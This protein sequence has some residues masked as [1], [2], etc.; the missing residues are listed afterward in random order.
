M[1]Q[2]KEAVKWVKSTKDEGGDTERTG[3][4]DR[5]RIF[6]QV[7]N[8]L[9]NPN[10]K[11]FVPR[12]QTK[13]FMNSLKL[14]TAVTAN[15]RHGFL[16]FLGM[17]PW[18]D[19]VWAGIELKKPHHDSCPL[20]DF[21]LELPEKIVRVGVDPSVQ[22]DSERVLATFDA[23]AK[24]GPKQKKKDRDAAASPLGVLD[25]MPHTLSLCSSNVLLL[26]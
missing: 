9:T 3:R 5:K 23:P 8:V 17:V 2:Q 20:V 18:G 24:Q 16:L 13:Q 26:G 14:R 22:P 19:G 11:V 4:I 21:V 6:L 7:M 1:E 25:F 12:G 15:R 10:M